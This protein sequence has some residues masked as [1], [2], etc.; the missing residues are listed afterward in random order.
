MI[1][2]TC[3]CSKKLVQDSLYKNGTVSLSTYYSVVH[4][5]TQT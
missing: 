2:N 4:M 1:Q 5:M 3:W